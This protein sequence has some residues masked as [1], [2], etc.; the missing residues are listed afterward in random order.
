MEVQEVVMEVQEES[1]LQ[2]LP[3]WTMPT[4]TPK[5]FYLRQQKCEWPFKF[6]FGADTKLGWTNSSSNPYPL[7]VSL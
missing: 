2:H 5:P 1:L 6:N 7:P 4:P 3:R